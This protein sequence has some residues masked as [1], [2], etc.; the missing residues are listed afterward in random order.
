MKYIKTYSL[1]AL[2]ALFFNA[3]EKNDSIYEL[4]K[5]NKQ[6]LVTEMLV[7]N[8]MTQQ[9]MDISIFG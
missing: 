8:G 6:M 1:I 9:E 2:I 4:G 5:N 7:L 3:C